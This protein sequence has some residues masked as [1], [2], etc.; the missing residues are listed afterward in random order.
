MQLAWTFAFAFALVAG[1]ITVGLLLLARLLRV[2]SRTTS[3]LRRRTYEC[4]EEPEGP[5]QIRFHA[6]YYV[7]AL[8]F[9]LFD[10]EAAFLFPWATTVGG[11]SAGL[12]AMALFVVVLMLGWWY[13]IKKGALRWQ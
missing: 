1:L 4:G 12:I 9:V 10:V 3:P 8:F 11:A 7:I 2:R 6:R 5:A 13:A